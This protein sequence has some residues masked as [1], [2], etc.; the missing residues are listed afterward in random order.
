M[1][2]LEQLMK[3]NSMV[4]IDMKKHL[5]NL[6]S[7][8]SFN[9]QDSLSEPKGLDCF[10]GISAGPLTGVK[11][12]QFTYQVSFPLSLVLNKKVM[13][14]YQMLFRH[15]FQ[16]KYLERLLGIAWLQDSKIILKN[17]NV[18]QNGEY[19]GL[20]AHLS[21]LRSK[22]LH[23]IQQM[24]YFMFFEVIEPHWTE[25]NVLIKTV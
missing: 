8:K 10:A 2:L 14:K 19:K 6:R 21:C 5:Q 16:C 24:I 20:V 7:G 4:G 23:F 25:M 9:I 17:Q 22:M 18:F 15:V 13:T 1:T 12:L 3:I 11:A